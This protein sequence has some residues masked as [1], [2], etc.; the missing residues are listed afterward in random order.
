VARGAGS[1]EKAAPDPS[2]SRHCVAVYGRFAPNFP[3][4]RPDSAWQQKKARM[5]MHPGLS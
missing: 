1:A 2:R 4:G 5:R 3:G